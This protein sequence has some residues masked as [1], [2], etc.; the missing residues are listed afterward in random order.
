MGLDM[1]LT[2]RRYLASYVEADEELSNKIKDT[3]DTLGLRP[4][5]IE[6]EAGYW[7]KANAIHDWF[8]TNIQ[9]GED[10]CGEYYLSKTKAQEL[11]DA[12]NQVL[13]D[14]SKAAEILPIASGFF[15]GS[16]DYD[17]WYFQ[18]LEQTKKI[19]EDVLKYMENYP[20]WEF[21]YTSSW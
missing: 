21:Y 2:G 7:R 9:D 6:V 8:V 19:M 1:Y 3:I 14:T 4:K 18:D 5:A 16:T 12:V 10:N 11:L 15:F 17:E 20:K 13:A